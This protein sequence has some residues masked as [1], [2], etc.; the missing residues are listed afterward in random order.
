MKRF[1]KK[2]LSFALALTMIMVLLPQ[3]VNAANASS[4]AT[5]INKFGLVATVNGNTVTVTGDKQGA[6][7]KLELK[8]DNIAVTVEWH[9][10]LTG[11]TTGISLKGAGS[12]G[13]F[14]MKS[15]EISGEST[16]PIIDNESYVSITI[17]GGL[18]QQAGTGSAIFNTGGS[19]IN[20]SGGTVHNRGTGQAIYSARSVNVTDVGR[21]IAGD[22][23]AIEGNGFYGKIDMKGGLAFAYGN[24]IDG[25]GDLFK[26]R[27][28]IDS[29]ISTSNGAT[30]IAWDKNS[31]KAEYDINSSDDIFTSSGVTAHWDVQDNHSG[32]SY[33]N[34]NTSNSGFI[35]LD[36]KVNKANVTNSGGLAEVTYAGTTIDLSTLTTLFTVD[37]NAGASTYTLENSDTTGTGNISNSTLTVTKAGTFQ[38]GLT[39]AATDTHNAGA[40]VI[41]TLTVNKGSQTA[42]ESLSKADVTTHGGNDG[43]IIG[44]APNTDYEF[45]EVVSSNYTSTIA[46]AAGEIAGLAAGTYVVRLPETDLYLASADSTEVVINQPA[47]PVYSVSLAPSTITFSSVKQGYSSV[48]PIE[49]TIKNTGNRSLSYLGLV[50]GGP[51][52]SSFEITPPGNN[53]TGLAVGATATVFVRPVT[54]LEAGSYSGYLVG[55]NDEDNIKIKERIPLNFTVLPLSSEKDIISVISPS[56]VSISGTTVSAIV[57][58]SEDSLTVDLIVSDLATWELFSDAACTNKISDKTMALSVGINTAYVKVTAEDGSSKVYI[59]EITRM[60]VPPVNSPPVILNVSVI[61]G[62][63]KASLMVEA[64][65]AAQP[66]S[67][68]WQVKGSWINIPGATSPEFDYEGLEPNTD[69]TI[70][71][72]VTDAEGRTAASN[73]ISFRTSATTITGLPQSQTMT[74]GEFITLTPSPSGGIW[75]FDKNFISMKQEGTR[76][77]LTALK[78]GKTEVNYQVGGSEITVELNIVEEIENI[79]LTGEHVSKLPWLLLLLASISFLLELLRW[80]RRE[81][82]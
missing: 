48:T 71:V 18:V 72:L 12:K 62:T 15:G 81:C 3:S 34:S 68:Q 75:S 59:L 47:E 67:Y 39:T 33:A 10:T 23:V 78:S 25:N 6:T 13:S 22:G 40:K 64:S 63:N 49:V 4:I 74:K 19:D 58:N 51:D 35:P 31:S 43:K 46:D 65:G 61:P 45:K 53:I 73:E 11:T 30:R 1:R 16:S 5:T 8:I 80:K 41:G 27:N 56:I 2:L 54:G 28:S 79:P 37:D 38:I 24:D 14:L 9:A 44:L 17:D 55:F 36:V 57:D 26:T 32:I 52:S 7:S 29:Y 66:L 50:F 21:I 82:L 77:V 42:P 60:G 76:A 70:R 20:I 69:Y